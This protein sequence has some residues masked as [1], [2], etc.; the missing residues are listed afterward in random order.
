MSDLFRPLN[1][2]ELARVFGNSPEIIRAFEKLQELVGGQIQSDILSLQGS[3]SAI[4]ADVES[5]HAEIA[6]LQSSAEALEFDIA[7]RVSG[8]L[9]AAAAYT[10]A[11]VESAD[12]SAHMHRLSTQVRELQ[13]RVD[14][15]DEAP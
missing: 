14:A 2:A 6:E 7:A 15:I 9:V 5:I 13:K 10:R 3:V 12:I 11:A 8:V 1:R 4:G